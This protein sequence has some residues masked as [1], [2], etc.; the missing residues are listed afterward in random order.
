MQKFFLGCLTGLVL[1]GVAMVVLFFAALRLGSRTPSV[2]ANSA[3]VLRL[4]GEL[5]EAAPFDAPLPFLDVETP[6]TV[7]EVHQLL[8][9]AAKDDRIKA[10]V[11]EP[12][13][14]GAGW[15]K[16]QQLREDLVRFKKSGK[17]LVAYL[18]TPGTAEYYIATAC[19]RIYMAPEDAL[20]L[21]GLRLELTYLK[22]TLDKIGVGIEVEAVGNF[23]DGGDMYSRTSARPETKEILNALLD[24]LYRDLIQTVAEGRKQK[25]EDAQKKIEEGPYTGTRAVKAGLV[26]EVK[27]EEEIYGPLKTAAKLTAR[28]YLKAAAPDLGGQRIAF[29]VGQGAITRGPGT[30][31]F[32]SAAFVKLLRQIREDSSIKGVILRVDSPGGDGIASDD[33][34]YAVKETG[35]K[36]PLVVSMSDYA[37]SGGYF[38]A[39]NGSPIVAY[40]NTLTGSIGVYLARPNLR[41]LYDKIGLNKEILSRG[42]YA[43]LDSEY[44]PLTDAERAKL[45]AELEDFYKGF[46]QRVAEGRKRK[47]EEMEPLARGRVWIGGD[48][49]KNGLIDELGGI[50]KA[51]EMLR[52]KAGIPAAEK[53][54][55]VPYPP[56][57]TLFEILMEQRDEKSLMGSMLR[58]VIGE[59]AAG[60]VQ[61][62]GGVM[63][64]MPYVIEVR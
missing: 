23:K 19:D 35:K 41:G 33:I 43:R 6:V 40:P 63:K 55:L 14:L 57:R 48:A 9:R 51:V 52:Q 27:F 58:T 22:G 45:R 34:L 7:L 5:P 59:R 11:F 20:N 49:R 26:D 25:P 36:K 16:I 15:A 32:T 24:A 31:G 46:V 60:L 54:T 64:A 1:L 53:I 30:D 12:R 13:F 47:Y 18:R 62:P 56:R 28:Q 61:R 29:V 3:L 42:P 37:A 38:V 39:M 44:A 2:A 50:D 17:P 8:E 21:K 4:D 10:V